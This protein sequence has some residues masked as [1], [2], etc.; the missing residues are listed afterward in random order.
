MIAV[1]ALALWGAGC[2]HVEKADVRKGEACLA[3]GGRSDYRIVISAKA[4]PSTHHAA[5][6]LQTYLKRITGARLPI[7]TDTEPERAREILVGRSSRFDSLGVAM[8]WFALGK[9][10]YVLRTVGERL[11]I[12]GGEPRGTLYGVYDLL[13]DKF[14]CR[15][16]TPE[17][18]RV[19]QVSQLPLPRLDERK[20]PVFEYRETYTWESFDGNW[21]A[22]NRLNGAGGRGRLLEKQNIRPPMPELDA[23]H[24][25]SVRFGFGFF[26]HTFD[27][28]VSSNQYFAVHP[29]Y[30]AL[31]SGKRKPT[32]LCCTNKDVI[33]LCAKAIRAGMKAQPEATVFSLSQSDNKEPCECDQCAALAKAEESGMGPLLH[34]VN[35]VAEGVEKEFPDKIVETLAYQWSRQPPKTM[36][37]RPN[38]VIRLA[39]IECCFA[40]PLASGCQEANKKFVADLQAWAKVCNRLWIWDYTTD[41]AHYLLPLPNKRLIDDNIRLFAANHVAGVFEQGTYDT[42]D[43]EMVALKAY[44]IAKFLWNPNYEEALATREF[45]DAYYGAAAP[46]IQRYL[47]LIHDYAEKQPVHVGIYAKPTSAHLTPELLTQASTLWDQAEATARKDAVALDRVRR[48]RMSVDYVIAE[49]ARTAM[50]TTDSKRNAQQR[51]LIALARKRFATFMQTFERSKLTRI[52]EWKDVD[53]ADYRKTLAADLG[54]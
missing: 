18:E 3:D 39:D 47:D 46:V 10:G 33:R 31:R 13:E 2:A 15:W 30:F 37:P 14:G 24:G 34:L 8:D 11:V 1:A 44:L 4:P 49:Q 45:L 12:A 21:M 25:G 54:I 42:F 23:R 50:K 19:P 26:V 22:R 6:E 41:Y 36:R 53:K 52:R 5:Q 48:S 17:I 32:Q 29:E 9:E 16:F 35:R 27:K 28:I 40:H 43:S 38:V 20:V 7:V 51:E